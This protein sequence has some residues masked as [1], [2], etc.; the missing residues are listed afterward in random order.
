MPLQL[1]ALTQRGELAARYFVRYV[2]FPDS[3]GGWEPRSSLNATAIEEDV[4]PLEERL[5]QGDGAELRERC[6]PSKER[7]CER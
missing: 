4:V 3:A 1:F 6:A 2:G 5:Q 7:S